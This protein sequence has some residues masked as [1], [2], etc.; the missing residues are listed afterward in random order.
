MNA[1][2]PALPPGIGDLTDAEA[3][4]LDQ[5]FPKSNT[6]RANCLTCGGARTFRWYAPSSREEVVTYDCPCSEQ[7]RLSRWLWHSGVGLLYQRLGW[8]DLTRPP[9]IG[10]DTY[11]DYLDHAP[12][13]VRT[14]LGIVFHGPRGTGKTMIGNLVLK[15]LIGRGFGCY[16]TSFTAMVDAYAKGWRNDEVLTWFDTRLR[17]AEVL[18]IDDLGRERNKGEG[19]VGES[20]LEEVIRHRVA[21]QMPTILT[22]NLDP[23]AAESVLRKSYG[24]HTLSLLSECSF[25]CE[26]D[27]ADIRPQIRLRNGREAKLGLMR[28][29]M[30]G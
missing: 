1:T 11:L 8:P 30:L 21:C 2:L 17:N 7:Y 25:F 10:V 12:S 5:T 15:D 16:Q 22:T 26:V 4:H 28:P 14:G 13:Y 29:V 23:G 20:M 3:R 6:N 18:F 24:G 19:T 9:F 27:G